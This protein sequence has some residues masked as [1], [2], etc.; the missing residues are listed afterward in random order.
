MPM[1]DFACE[2][3]AGFE[4]QVRLSDFDKAQPCEACGETTGTRRVIIAAPA[5]VLKGDSGWTTKAGRIRKQMATKNKKLAAK[6]RDLKGDGGVPSL[7]PNVNG[8]QVRS[9]GEAR[10]LAASKGKDTSTYDSHV[11]KEKRTS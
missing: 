11:R 2:C 7:T 1:Y 9:W 10:K 8:E 5:F 3:G 4:R 6:E